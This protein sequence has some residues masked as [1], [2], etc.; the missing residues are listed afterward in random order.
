ML[1]RQKVRA[2]LR[3]AARTG[4]T[5]RQDKAI[6]GAP[7]LCKHEAYGEY[8]VSDTPAIEL[9]TAQEFGAFFDYLNDHLADNG[10][11][12]GLYF[13]PLSRQQS[14]LPPERAEAFRKG[15]QIEVGRAGWRRLWTARA[16]QGEIVGHIDLRCHA[17]AGAGH[18]CVMGMGVHR[19]HRGRGL[20]RA[21]IAHA[22]QWALA[23]PFEWI[24]LQVLSENQPALELYQRAGFDRTGETVDLFR[25]DGRSFSYTSMSK[26][27]ARPGSDMGH[28]SVECMDNFQITNDKAALDVPL[29]HQFLSQQSSWAKGIPLATVQ[30]AIAHSLCFGGFLGA[31]QVAFARVITDGA[32]FANLVDVFVLPEQRGCGYGKAMMLAVMAHP[33]L[34]GLRRFTLATGDAH[35]LYARFGFTAP[36]RPQ[37]LM[38]RYFPE[39]YQDGA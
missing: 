27:L 16:A 12:G 19:A 14:R 26:R 10:K 15:L 36:L 32:T 3:L 8:K 29:I 39:L 24:D 6:G 33:D 17:E 1:A 20:G 34:Q 25:F 7:G 22:E 13:Q 5:R 18:R 9:V 23:G 4:L 37:S 28:H 21:L 38:E 2:T 35:A 30:R 11:G 31:R